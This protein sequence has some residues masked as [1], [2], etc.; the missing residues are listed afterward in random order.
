MYLSPLYAA[1]N[2]CTGAAPLIQTP[3]L[4]KIADIVKKQDGAGVIA[5]HL[6]ALSSSAKESY[7]DAF[8]KQKFMILRDEL[9]K[10]CL[11]DWERE[12]IKLYD[13]LFSEDDVELLFENQY[14]RNEK[15]DG[16]IVPVW[17]EDIAR[18]LQ[19]LEQKQQELK[20]NL[21]NKISDFYNKRACVIVRQ[22]LGP[23]EVIK[24]KSMHYAYGSKTIFVFEECKV[25]AE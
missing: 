18:K 22:K 21:L 24:I 1:N 14:P 17:P 4:S 3:E 9:E 6:D 16:S 8:F 10:P 15:G 23:K 25:K 5:S 12:S 13:D 7:D 11:T 2:P 19:V 20:S